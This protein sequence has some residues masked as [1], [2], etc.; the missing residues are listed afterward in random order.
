MGEA[1]EEAFVTDLH[2]SL[3]AY[4]RNN[5]GLWGGNR[6]LLDDCGVDDADDASGVI[7]RALYRK[8]MYRKLKE[9]YR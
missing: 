2:F 9:L 1:S 4:I 7:L 6:A 3:G 5:F 8:L